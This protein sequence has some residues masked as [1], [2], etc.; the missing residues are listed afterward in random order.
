[1]PPVMSPRSHSPRILETDPGIQGELLL[2][3]EC[4]KIFIKYALI[5]QTDLL[6]T[7]PI[8]SILKQSVFIALG[9]GVFYYR[10]IKR[11]LLSSSLRNS[12][13]DL[14]HQQCDIIVSKLN[15][16]CHKCQ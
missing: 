11:W 7:Y 14:F 16:I 9:I 10:A 1:M 3:N 15:A 12:V 13:F 8:L 4:L 5:L 2:M 6:L